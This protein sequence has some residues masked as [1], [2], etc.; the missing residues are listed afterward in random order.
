MG[1]HAGHRERMR[2]QLL[3][4]GFENLAP[5]NALELLLYYTSPRKDTN[6]LAH[7]LIDKFGSFSA[8]LDASYEELIQIEDV[9]ES[10]AVFIK[11]LPNSF[12]YYMKSKE[13]EH[14]IVSDISKAAHLL[15]PYFIGATSEMLYTLC[16][17]DNKQLIRISKIS[18][19]TVNR[20]S[21]MLKKI[22]S[23]AIFTN[24]TAIILAHNHAAGNPTPTKEDI[25]ATQSIKQAL[26]Y[27]QVELL[28]HLVIHNTNFVSIEAVTQGES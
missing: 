18:E 4:A 12:S 9:G 26:R 16:L 15:V 24:A 19:G 25:T 22:M 3:K 20:T 8:V 5:H 13:L 14:P 10:T 2:K 21:V 7:R 17:N 23:E 6:A 27:I 28:D 11:L 1:Q